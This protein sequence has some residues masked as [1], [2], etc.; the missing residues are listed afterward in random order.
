MSMSYPIFSPSCPFMAF[1]TQPHA[2]K[3]PS[4]TCFF[5]FPTLK[6]GGGGRPYLPPKAHPIPGGGGRRV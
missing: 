3:I 4:K 6:I 5:E 2:L 1:N